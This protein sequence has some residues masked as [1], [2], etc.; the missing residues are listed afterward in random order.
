MS[1]RCSAK[2]V[3]RTQGKSVVNS[4]AYISR[5]RLTSDEL[6]LTFDYT[7]K[8]SSP[9][10]SSKIYAPKWADW[11]LDRSTLWNKVEQRET[12]KK[13][14]FARLIELNLPH[15][16]SPESRASTLEAFVKIHFIS[17]GMVADV[18]IHSPDIKG[19]PRNH[20]AHILL[21]LRGVDANG[22]VG[23][24][25]REWNKKSVLE[26]WREMWALSCSKSLE[27][28][29][30][31]QEAEQW[32]HGHLTLKDQQNAAIERDD[33]QYAEKCNHIPD[34]HHGPSIHAIIK[35]E[36]E[37]YV[38]QHREIELKDAQISKDKRLDKLKNKCQ[39]LEAERDQLKCVL[40]LYRPRGKELS[41]A[42][43]NRDD[44][45]GR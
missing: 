32:R 37:S 1:F 14:Q 31:T 8:Q 36:D 39:K 10:L 13:A 16:L 24:K 40:S 17:L 27:S 12:H 21:T 44:D 6:G 26:G 28:A 25:I 4:A 35:N 29:G 22:F 9:C 30:F 19:D 23:N 11:T 34:K 38:Q 20:H 5:S 7:S 41:R 45:R 33:L 3:S 2:I 18:N 42:A 43:P 15:Q